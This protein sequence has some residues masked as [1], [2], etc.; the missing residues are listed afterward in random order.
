MDDTP[1]ARAGMRPN[2]VITEIEGKSTAGMAIEDAADRIR[3][4]IGTKVT[5]TVK[6]GTNLITFKIPRQEIRIKS[7]FTK[8]LEQK[9][10]GY[11]RLN[12]FISESALSEMQEAIAKFKKKRG[13][14]LDLRGN[15]G[16]L[17][18]NAVDISDLFLGSN[19]VIVSMV[20]RNHD[21]QVFKASGGRE[22]K[23]PMVILIDGGSASASEILSGALKDHDRA[24]LIGTTT[25]GKGLV[26]KINP[27]SDGSGLNITVSKYFTPEGTDI[28]KKGI[29]PDLTV[30]LSEKDILNNRDLQLN[31]AIDFLTRQTAK[32]HD[33]NH[34]HG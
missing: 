34:P 11:I 6:R 31:A 3:G 12:S 9:S 25:F 15:Y 20:D 30:K 1:A 27:L 10:I 29:A 13:L 18:S 16:G 28:N 7:V 4:E 21:R 2:D 24:T 26:Q 23:Q 5:L 17:L 32:P 22:V 8:E 19:E 14:I 33:E